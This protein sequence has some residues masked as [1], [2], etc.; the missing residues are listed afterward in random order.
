MISCNR[1]Q[2]SRITRL[3][4]I[5]G[6]GL[7]EIVGPFYIKNMKIDSIELVSNLEF[8]YTFWHNQFEVQLLSID[9]SEK[10]ADELILILENMLMYS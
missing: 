4:N 10:E 6:D 1:S 9:M 8:K 7:P 3:V 5:L 2:K